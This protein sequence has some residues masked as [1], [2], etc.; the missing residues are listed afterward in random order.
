M[1]KVV[2]IDLKEIISACMRRIWLIIISTVVAAAVV[3]IYTTLFVT[4]VYKTEA[5]FYVN[6]SV[7]GRRAC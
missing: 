6:N 1:E 7:K 3:Y 5:T 4:P 2:E